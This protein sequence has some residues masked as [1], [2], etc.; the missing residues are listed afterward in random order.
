MAECALLPPVRFNFCHAR[1][2]DH[3]VVW[4]SYVGRV[5]LSVCGSISSSKKVDRL[6]GNVRVYFRQG[7]SSRCGGAHNG[8]HDGATLRYSRC[9]IGNGLP[10]RTEAICVSQ[11][12]DS[13][14]NAIKRNS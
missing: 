11:F 9:N 8:R 10:G 5:Q 6:S 14:A 13:I 2:S 7:A 3:L 12:G 4:P 1:T